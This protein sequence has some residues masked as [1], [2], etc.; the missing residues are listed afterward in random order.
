MKRAQRCRN[1]LSLLQEQLDEPQSWKLIETGLK[2]TNTKV[3]MEAC[4]SL[5]KRQ[6]DDS[7]RLLAGDW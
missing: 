1:W 3:R 5:G 7:L 4:R 6:D 2:D